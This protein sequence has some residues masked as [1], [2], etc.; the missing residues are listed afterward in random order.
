MKKLRKELSKL[1]TIL[2]EGGLLTL[3]QQQRYDELYDEVYS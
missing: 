1:Q 3:K 2:D